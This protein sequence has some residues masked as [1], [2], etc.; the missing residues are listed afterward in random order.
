M[1]SLQFR[2]LAGMAALSNAF[3]AAAAG[4]AC[5][6]LAEA[7]A[8]IYGMPTHMYQIEKAGPAG[9]KTRSNELIYL[10]NKMY[11]MVGGKWSVSKATPADMAAS[12]KEA[13]K[14]QQL[15]MTCS[16]VRDEV[17]NGEAT[18]LY[19]AHRKTEDGTTDA[20]FWVSKSKGAPVK[21]EMDMDD[22][23]GG[24]MHRSLRYEYT[25]VQAPAVR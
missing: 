8:K 24:R 13:R 25:N 1:T 3:T 23:A 6:S 4:S 18:T 2:L 22:G 10:N 21:A 19:S 9:G 14:E 11:I 5:Q 16:V 17:V 12:Q 7:N 15:G 20:Q